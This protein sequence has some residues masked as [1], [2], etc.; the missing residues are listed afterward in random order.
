MKGVK[1]TAIRYGDYT[2]HS[3]ILISLINWKIQ[4]GDNTIIYAI[5][6]DKFIKIGH[7]LFWNFKSTY[8]HMYEERNQFDLRGTC[9]KNEMFRI[10]KG[11]DIQKEEE[12]LTKI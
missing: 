10:L 12:L 2:S 11:N 7:L 4:N 9:I 8:I 3:D 5:I 6:C 1:S